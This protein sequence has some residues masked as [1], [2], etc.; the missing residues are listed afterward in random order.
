MDIKEEASKLR[1]KIEKINWQLTSGIA[2]SRKQIYQ[3]KDQIDI[4]KAHLKALENKLTKLRLTKMN[5]KLHL[6]Y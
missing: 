5:V 6:S 2:L 4:L 1:K 3:K